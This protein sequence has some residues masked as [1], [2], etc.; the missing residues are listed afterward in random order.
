LTDHFQL[1]VFHAEKQTDS[2]NIILLFRKNAKEKMVLPHIF[3]GILEFLMSLEF[4]LTFKPRDNGKKKIIRVLSKE[5]QKIF[6]EYIKNS[7]YYNLYIVALGTGMRGGELR[8]L[9]WSD[10]NFEEKKI[11][12]SGTLK[13]RK[14]EGYRKDTPKTKMSEREIPMIDEVYQILKKQHRE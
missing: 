9:E 1:S 6:L 10:I 8:A 3:F 12:I 14:K 13:Y 7:L 11:H 2:I 4:A 5:E